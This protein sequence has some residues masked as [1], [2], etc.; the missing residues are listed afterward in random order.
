MDHILLD[1]KKYIDLWL[2]TQLVHDL[3]V[4]S[5]EDHLLKSDC[6]KIICTIFS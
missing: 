6:E 5:M 2:N 1:T 4:K 3:Y